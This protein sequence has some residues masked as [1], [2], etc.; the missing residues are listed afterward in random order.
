MAVGCFAKNLVWAWWDE[1]CRGGGLRNGQFDI[2]VGVGPKEGDAGEE[3]LGVDGA[4]GAGAI[5][6][7]EDA[8]GGRE[9]G[10]G[11]SS[12]HRAGSNSDLRVVA[13]ALRFAHFAASHDVKL[14]VLF[15]KPDRRV[16]GDTSLAEGGERDVALAVDFGGDG[17]ADILTM[18]GSPR[19][20][21]YRRL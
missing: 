8:S 2:S 5:F 7:G 12:A 19:L 16:D 21:G 15:G 6:R 3:V 18:P 20:A 10:A 14:A 11:D 4:A 1:S 9:F 17:H 13:D